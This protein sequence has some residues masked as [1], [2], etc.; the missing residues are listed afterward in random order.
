M[1]RLA[2][3]V[4]FKK[5]I[6]KARQRH[7][8]GY[9][10]AVIALLSTRARRRQPLLRGNLSF[11]SGGGHR[12]EPLQVCGGFPV[13]RRVG[14]VRNR[15][16]VAAPG[17]AE[18]LCR[19]VNR[20]VPSASGECVERGSD[21]RGHRIVEQNEGMGCGVIGEGDGIVSRRVAF[22]IAIDEAELPAGSIACERL[23]ARRTRFVTAITTVR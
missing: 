4:E 10:N 9:R 23:D 7:V 5:W 8:F 1:H 3:A 13:D 14:R 2:G 17:H 16:N 6:L 20:G 12:G 22:V 21:G 18:D 19:V 15:S 11:W